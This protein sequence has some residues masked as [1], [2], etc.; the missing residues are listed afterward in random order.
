MLHESVNYLGQSE[1]YKDNQRVIVASP[2][3]KVA[4]F[5]IIRMVAWC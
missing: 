4:V 3:E 2:K 5:S 1:H